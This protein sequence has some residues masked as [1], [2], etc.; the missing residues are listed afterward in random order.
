MVLSIGFSGTTVMVIK[1]NHI[2]YHYRDIPPMSADQVM[3]AARWSYASQLLYNPVLAMVKNAVLVFFYRIGGLIT[4]IR[5]LIYALMFLNT[6]LMISVFF[7]TSLQCTPVRKAINPHISGTCI[8][9]AT[10][11]VA[12]AALALFTDCLVMMIPIWIT[13]SLHHMGWKKRLGV[14]SLLSLGFTVT[15]ISAYRLY[16]TANSYY[17]PPDHDPTYS[18]GGC[19]S[20]VEVNLAIITACGPF[21]KPL[22]DAWLPN[23][24]G[25]DSSG[26]HPGSVPSYGLTTIGGSNPSHT[27]KRSAYV[28][29]AGH[30]IYGDGLDHRTYELRSTARNSSDNVLRDDDDDDS[31]TKNMILPGHRGILK[32]MAVDVTYSAASPEDGGYEYGHQRKDTSESIV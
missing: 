5:I 24:F 1:F 27:D 30:T 28:A 31:S 22:V 29:A 2:G 9:T 21:L 14:F 11:F 15:G 20:P 32:R 13:C 19:A 16:Y 7:T 23:A 10:F 18:L 12:S 4:R 25:S 26:K 8:N 6:A 3:L 17:G